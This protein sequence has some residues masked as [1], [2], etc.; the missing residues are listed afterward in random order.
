MDLF[1]KDKYYMKLAIKE[2]EKAFEKDEVPVGAIV[3]CNNKIIARAYNMSETLTD[4]TAHAEMQVITAGTSYLGGKYLIG[5]T[6]YI[7][8][9]PCV[10][11]AGALYWSQPSRVVFGA[12][13]EKRGYSRLAKNIMHP[14]TKITG[15][16]LE[17]ES[18]SLLRKFFSGK[19]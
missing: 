17:S 19:R 1:E 11:C 6:V 8:L 9:E 10:M 13:D 14:K 18:S 12:Y 5:C 2:A 3:V 4:P 7:T 15:G 16:V